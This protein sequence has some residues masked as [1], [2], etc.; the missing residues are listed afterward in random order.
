MYDGLD[1]ILQV[2]AFDRTQPV[3]RYG[4]I[5]RVTHVVHPS[6]HA[7]FLILRL[8]GLLDYQYQITQSL[9]PADALSIAFKIVSYQYQLE[10]VVGM[11]IKNRLI[12]ILIAALLSLCAFNGVAAAPV[13]K[14]TLAPYSGYTTQPTTATQTAMVIVLVSSS[15]QN[16]SV[17]SLNVTVNEKF[18]IV[19]ALESGTS[20]EHLAGIGGATIN[21]LT[22][23]DQQKW[24]TLGTLTTETGQNSTLPKG[25]FEGIIIAP[26]SPGVF[27]VMAKY[28][29]DSQYAPMQ[30]NVV[31][32]TVTQ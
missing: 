9:L 25:T 5:H 10:T 2:I 31:Q 23:D 13:N 30:S 14:P 15:N 3:S 26:S 1:H 21:I 18:G 17:S 27:Y 6:T 24:T 16:G 7:F 19:G 28:G 12:C 11:N 4:R 32:L 22:S 20:S 29:G 8:Q